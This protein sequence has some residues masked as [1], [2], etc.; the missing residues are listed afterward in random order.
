MCNVLCLRSWFAIFTLFLSL[1]VLFL[2]FVFAPLASLP[3]LKLLAFINR[4]SRSLHQQKIKAQRL[5]WT[6]QWRTKH[7]KGRVELAQKKKSKKTTKVYKAIQGIDIDE[8][9]KKRAQKPDFRKAAR[10]A[11][12]R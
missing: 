5:T 3:G 2:C 1:V 7:K 9:K 4:K 8:L 11:S 6:Q 12:L 10:D